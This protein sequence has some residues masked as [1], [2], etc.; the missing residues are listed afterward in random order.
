MT[1][2]T[3]IVRVQAPER[4]PTFE[5]AGSPDSG[6]SLLWVLETLWRYKV[7]LAACWLG[8]TALCSVWAWA[9]P[10]V[11]QAEAVILAE[12]LTASEARSGAAPHAAWQ[13]RLNV[14]GWQV[15]SSSQLTDLLRQ[16]HL[17]GDQAATPVEMAHRIWNSVRITL[18]PER[19]PDR[20]ATFRITCQQADRAMA[21]QVANRLSHL[22]IQELQRERQSQ[23]AG[24]YQFLGSQLTA[25]RAK[26]ERHEKALSDFRQRYA[27]ELPEQEKGLLAALGWLQAES[28][29]T[30]E[31]IGRA[32][33][34]RALL[35][36]EG[37]AARLS[38]A[39]LAQR[40]EP[41][42]PLRVTQDDRPV[43]SALKSR[44][45]QLKE[46]LT[47]LRMHYT[48]NHPD[49]KRLRSELAQ[50]E[51]PGKREANGTSAHGLIT[52]RA[53]AAGAALLPQPAPSVL[54]QQERVQSLSSQLIVAQAEVDSLQ[55]KRRRLAAEMGALRMALGR[56][57]ERKR[58][59][60]ALLRDYEIANAHYR[61]LANQRS[62]AEMAVEM[63]SQQQ[64][65]RLRVMEQ[66]R[67]PSRPI[68]PNRWRL[69]VVG[70]LAGL[71]I[72]G[73][74]AVARGVD[75]KTLWELLNAGGARGRAPGALRRYTSP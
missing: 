44:A 16:L 54:R 22:L 69:G 72:G 68:K 42:A 23:I 20:S 34:K 8:V 12:S 2:K 21:A 28:A 75:R 7:S 4:Q 17:P 19:R 6:P 33:R 57:P 3:S 73:L 55:A 29:S 25:A 18:G 64:T 63:E 61:S 71:L 26:L 24:A 37:E 31:G 65:E 14:A 46:R 9:L 70:S 27:G 15:L 52:Q 67:I 74:I 30:L 62:S 13:E 66:A 53:A 41:T 40:A 56:L 43:A 48:E 47:G 45:E 60:A 50:L 49:V 38:A 11:Y 59:F 36:A 58:E 1:H 39:S 35:A 32:E 51:E 10:S 5:T